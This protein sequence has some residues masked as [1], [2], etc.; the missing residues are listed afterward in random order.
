MEAN[1]FACTFKHDESFLSQ[2][3]TRRHIDFL[4]CTRSDGGPGSWP[5]E[6][7]WQVALVCKYNAVVETLVSGG[8]I[9]P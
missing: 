8:L 6:R 5:V 9:G 3:G 1:H 2:S 4:Y 7:R